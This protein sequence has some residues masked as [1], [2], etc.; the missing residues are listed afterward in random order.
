MLKISSLYLPKLSYILSILF[1]PP[2]IIIDCG[3]PPLLR[4]GS[5]TTEN[6]TVFGSKA[7]Y[8]C[9]YGY[10]FSENSNMERICQVSGNWSN[11]IIQCGDL[12]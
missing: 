2:V 11:E 8:M 4:N 12:K 3:V 7:T 10:E 5:V 6:G 9:N 1:P